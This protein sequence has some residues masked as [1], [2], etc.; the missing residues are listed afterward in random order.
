M[1][2]LLPD[3]FP[4]RVA[5]GPALYLLLVFCTCSIDP[6]LVQSIGLEHID[7]HITMS[8]RYYCSRKQCS[9]PQSLSAVPTWE[10]LQHG[11]QRLCASGLSKEGAGAQG[12]IPPPQQQQNPLKVSIFRKLQELK[13]RSSTPS[14]DQL[15]PP[16]YH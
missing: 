15:Y 2:H 4:H 12:K 3:G 13:G 6:L 11:C 14:S 10:I 8:L 1:Q 5:P 9:S 16:N 7:C